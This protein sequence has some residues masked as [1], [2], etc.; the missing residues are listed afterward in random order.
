MFDIQLTPE[1]D[2]WLTGVRDVTTRARITARLRQAGMGHLG[3]WKSLG[4][5]LAEM[6]LHWGPGWRLYFT[7]QQNVLIV[8]LAGGDKS[9]QAVDIRRAHRLL[10]HW[11]EA[12]EKR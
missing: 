7:R 2:R 3:D 4:E 10:N 6:R 9:T 11:L 1:F 8:M 12:G 5:G